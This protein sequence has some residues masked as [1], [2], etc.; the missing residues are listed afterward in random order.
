MPLPPEMQEGLAKVKDLI[1]EIVKDNKTKVLFCYTEDEDL[2]INSNV[3]VVCY[4]GHLMEYIE[5]YNVQ[6]LTDAMNVEGEKI[7]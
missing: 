3:C 2:V 7:H 5:T 4:V 6:H 1:N